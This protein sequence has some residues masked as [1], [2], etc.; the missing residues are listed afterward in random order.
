M[1]SEKERDITPK[2]ATARP[3][4]PEERDALAEE[5]ALDLRTIRNSKGLT[6]KDVSSLTRI[7][8]QNLKAIEEQ[9]FDLL[10]EPIYARAFI[11]TYAKTLDVDGRKVLSLYDDYLKR[12][13]PD[14]EKND[15][16]KRLA[17]K[18]RHL[19][20]WI[21]IIIVS[22]LLVLVGA[23]YLYQW[24]T[25]DR[26]ASEGV[27]RAAEV[28]DTVKMEAAPV[29]I[30]PPESGDAT[31]E[32]EGKFSEAEGM[33]PADLPVTGDEQQTDE[34]ITGEPQAMVVAEQPEGEGEQPVIEEQR[35]EE[36][37]APDVTVPAAEKEYT[38]VM[39][40]SELTWIE[41]EKDGGPPFEV[42]LR[43][44]ERITER[45]SKRF[46]LVIGNAGGVDVRFQG[47][48]LGSLGEHGQVIRL[49]LPRGE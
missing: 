16:L 3:T 43:P 49:T 44:G 25:S 23:F 22:A 14:Q 41:I 20:V 38:L 24:S 17:A 10:P 2:D 26:Q 8:P 5:S 13:K 1:M 30:P 31:V 33:P 11:D 15:V 29:E 4:K 45:A 19:E 27:Y 34:T 48:S 12:L 35:P 42:M 46:G 28:E 32:K 37:T 18:R 7:S 47:K 39:E 40:A 6:L 9:R 21:W 36:T